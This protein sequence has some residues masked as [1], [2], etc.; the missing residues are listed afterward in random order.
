M[1]VIWETS[2]V[3]FFCLTVVIG[4]GAAYMSGRAIAKTWQPIMILAFYIVILTAAVRFFHWGLFDGTFFSPQYYF[5]DFVVLGL[6]AA[7]GFRLTRTRQMVTQYYW[8]YRKTSPLTW[9]DVAR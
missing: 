9:E 5:V 7:I 4:G 2:L 1:G 6:F 3:V 8:L